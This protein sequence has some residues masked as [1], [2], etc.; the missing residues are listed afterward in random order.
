[1]VTHALQQS[2]LTAQASMRPHRLPPTGSLLFTVA[3]TRTA[4]PCN[5][6]QLVRLHPSVLPPTH[7]VVAVHCDRHPR[8]AH[9]LAQLGLQATRVHLLCVEQ[10]W[11]GL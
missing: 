8:V 7:R 6:T 5:D 11:F 3:G 1:M 9:Q 4:A 2:T 10:E